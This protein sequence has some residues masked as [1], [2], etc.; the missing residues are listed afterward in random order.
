MALD[1][2]RLRRGGFE[3]AEDGVEALDVPNL[4]YQLALVR[5]PHQLGRLL[6]ALGHRLLHEHVPAGFEQ[7][8]GDVE[9]RR[10]GRDDAQGI[11]RGGRFRHGCEGPGAVCGGV[12][13]G[14]LGVCIKDAGEVDRAGAG[15]F[16]VEPGVFLAQRASADDGDADFLNSHARSVPL[17]RRG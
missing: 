3:V 6:G 4:Q 12:L 7:R 14:G 15:E 10:G 11:A 17:Q 5:E 13:A 9:M 8:L 2:A 1:E 16:G